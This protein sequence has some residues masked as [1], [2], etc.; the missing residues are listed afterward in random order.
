[1]ESSNESTSSSSLAA[2]SLPKI[3]IQ[4]IITQ[5]SSPP[6]DQ[7]AEAKDSSLIESSRQGL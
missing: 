3:E 1:M 4:L 2:V 7:R 6:S 5:K